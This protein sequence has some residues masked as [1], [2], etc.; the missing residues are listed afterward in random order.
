MCAKRCKRDAITSRVLQP[1]GKRE[2]GER[3]LLSP[4]GQVVA[5]QLMYVPVHDR[6][7][8]PLH[9]ARRYLSCQSLVVDECGGNADTADQSDVHDHPVSIGL[10][11]RAAYPGLAPTT[12]A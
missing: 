10:K 11:H 4:V 12:S 8:K 1:P 9:A 5:D 7:I 2:K 3:L 6:E